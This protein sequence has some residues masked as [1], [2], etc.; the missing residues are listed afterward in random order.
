MEGEEMS[1]QSGFIES[2]P[3]AKEAYSFTLPKKVREVLGIERRFRVL[4]FFIDEGDLVFI[5]FE[6]KGQ[7]PIGSSDFYSSFQ[8]TVPSTVRRLLK[9][10]KGDSVGFYQSEA[11][12]KIYIR[13]M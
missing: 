6:G 4:T 10:G 12:G 11:E 5:G 9:I 8:I 13:K 1:D 3:L 7:Q 2:A